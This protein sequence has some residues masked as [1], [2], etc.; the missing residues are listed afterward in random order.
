MWLHREDVFE[1]WAPSVSVWAAWAKPVLFAHL[2]LG[3]ELETFALMAAPRLPLPAWAPPADGATAI[4]L[5]VPGP[6]SVALAMALAQAGFRPVPLFNAVPPPREIELAVDANILPAR[7]VVD[8]QSIVD[9]VEVATVHHA[10]TLAELRP[11]AP[12]VF[13]LDSARRLGRRIPRHGDFD[14]RSLS[15][16]TDFPSAAFLHSHGVT[17]A[18]LVTENAAEPSID[19]AH[20]LLRWQQAGLALRRGDERGDEARPLVVRRPSWF[21]AVWHNALSVVGLERHPLGGFGGTPE[22]L[23]LPSAG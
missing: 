9:A 7:A 22:K 8:V 21:R 6:R 5:D 16:P 2:P 17:C 18:L 20:T 4:V 1:L 23:M 14:N 19:L 12:P 13:L 3:L 11:Q 15:L 10:Q